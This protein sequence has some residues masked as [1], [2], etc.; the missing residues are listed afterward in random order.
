MKN[1][2]KKLKAKHFRYLSQEYI[3]DPMKYLIEFFESETSI[4]DWLAD[5]NMLINAASNSKMNPPRSSIGYLTKKLIEQVELAY[6][7][8]RKCK[9]KT[10]EHPLKFNRGVSDYWNQLLATDSSASNIDT[11]ADNISRFFSYESLQQ[12]YNILDDLWISLGD[13]DNGFLGNN[14]HEILAVKEFLLRLAASLGKIYE[15]KT[16]PTNIIENQEDIEN[17]EHQNQ[18]SLLESGD[19]DTIEKLSNASTKEEVL[20]PKERIILPHWLD[21]QPYSIS[22]LKD[23]FDKDDLNGWREDI[24]YWYQTVIDEKEF[25]SADHENSK[26]SGANLLF[27]YTCLYSL[28]EMLSNKFEESPILPIAMDNSFSILP[29]CQSILIM[30]MH[31][32]IILYYVSNEELDNPLSSLLATVSIYNQE[33]WNEILY[34]WINYGLAKNRYTG[35]YS[36]YSTRIYQTMIK[37]I[38]L[39]YLIAFS[40]DIEFSNQEQIAPIETK[41]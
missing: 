4:N 7:I 33:E 9:L 1:T 3:D 28:L 31:E 40:E 37:I 5:L 29:E 6:V 11:A 20:Y 21:S 13:R 30:H 25:W 12:W 35:A 36:D 32:E 15:I 39:A 22:A 34:E 27:N 18:Q 8:F 14:G 16:L 23:F 17:E 38:E 26:F 41:I 19:I 2:Q 10:I 24:R